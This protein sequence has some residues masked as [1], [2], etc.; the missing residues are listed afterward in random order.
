MSGKQ[1]KM[2]GNICINSCN[3]N[4]SSMAIYVLPLLLLVIVNHI[5]HNTIRLLSIVARVNDKLS[6]NVSTLL[7]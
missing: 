4:E 2:V 5:T 7:S 6:V 3:S 1:E